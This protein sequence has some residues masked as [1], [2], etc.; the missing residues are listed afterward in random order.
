MRCEIMPQKE[1]YINNKR[2]SW[3]TNERDIIVI[4][5]FFPYSYCFFS[6][7]KIDLNATASTKEDTLD[8][9]TWK[10]LLISDSNTVS[11][12]DCSTLQ[13]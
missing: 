2:K 9:H 6:Q 13:E 7:Q 3:M 11:F 8:A 10:L 4:G 5:T 1:L 12:P